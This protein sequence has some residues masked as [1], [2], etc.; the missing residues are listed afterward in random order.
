M[1]N[2]ASGVHSGTAKESSDKAIARIR[3]TAS[4]SDGSIVFKTDA[5][6]PEEPEFHYESSAVDP[7]LFEVL[8]AAHFLVVSPS[9]TELE[10][11]IRAELAQFPGPQM[12]PSIA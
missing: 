8:S 12:A 3:R 7:V 11:I 5:L 6:N 9:I 4:Y 2:I 1:A 10:R